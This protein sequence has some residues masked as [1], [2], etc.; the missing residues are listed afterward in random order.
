MRFKSS[1]STCASSERRER[2]SAEHVDFQF[3]S[4]QDSSQTASVSSLCGIK[5]RKT[6][7]CRA[8]SAQHVDVLTPLSA[9]MK[10]WRARKT[11]L[12]R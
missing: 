11:L 6:L 7:V 12:Y 10:D 4:T 1:R 5:E 3:Y 9:L 8:R 2:T